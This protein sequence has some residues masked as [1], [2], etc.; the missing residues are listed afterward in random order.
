[1]P[2][3]EEI[4]TGESILMF[5]NIGVEGEA[6]PFMT[7][8]DFEISTTSG[9]AETAKSGVIDGAVDTARLRSQ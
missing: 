3:V 2:D 7:G 5:D 1:M 4:P 8:G 6:T 9:E